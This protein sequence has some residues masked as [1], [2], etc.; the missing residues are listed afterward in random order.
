MTTIVTRSGKGSPLTNNEVDT[1]FTN[2]N[3]FKLETTNNLS[4]VA[5]AATAR[6]NLLAAKSGANTDITSVTLTT[7]TIST[8]PSGTTDIVNKA[9]ADALQAGTNFHAACNYATTAALS[10]A[11]TYNNGTSGVGA[12]LTASSNGTLTIDGYTFVSGDVGKRILVKNESAGANNGIYTLTQAGTGGLPYTLTRAT[13][14]D[15]VGTGQ[16]EVAAGDLTLVLSGSANS[17]TQWVQQTP[18][19]ITLGTTAITFV[20][21]GNG[22][23]Y[24]AGTGLTL[25]GS[26]F[27]ITNQGTA[28]TYGSASQVPVFTTNAQGQ[29][30]S[31]T[32][33]NIAISGSAVSGNIT[34]NAANVT[35]TVAIAN[36]GTGATTVAGA[37]TNLQVDPAGTAVALAIA[38]G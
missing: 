30:T 18:A 10:P 6:G 34:G 8:T 36:G 3:S 5:S 33:T 28:N 11:N 4:D 16:D 12:T 15:Q 22:T 31:V 19:P 21:F 26:T 35:G 9:Y 7:G 23:I 2:L 1:N 29:V 25:A 37:Q 14:Y 13:D 17:N 27:S 38:L 32:N 24:S 20:Q